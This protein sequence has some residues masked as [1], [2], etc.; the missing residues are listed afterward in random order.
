MRAPRSRGRQRMV[1]LC[2]AGRTAYRGCWPPQRCQPQHDRPSRGSD[3]PARAATIFIHNG[4][5][6]A[7]VGCFDRVPS[8]KL[9]EED[10]CIRIKFGR[11]FDES[12]GPSGR[13]CDRDGVRRES[14]ERHRSQHSAHEGCRRGARPHLIL[15]DRPPAVKEDRPRRAIAAPFGYRP[16]RGQ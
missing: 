13:S 14:S 6:Q 4:A 10:V 1:P 9:G 5:P 11:A 16:S 3:K 12:L 2:S 15:R 8:E 7:L